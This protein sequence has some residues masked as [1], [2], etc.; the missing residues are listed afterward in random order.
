M[1]RKIFSIACT[2]SIIH[3][4]KSFM[5]SITSAQTLC[6][7]DL[8][9]IFVDTTLRPFELNNIEFSYVN[10]TCQP[11]LLPSL[12]SA[13][14]KS[15]GV[16]TNSIHITTRQINFCLIKNPRRFSFFSVIKNL[17]KYQQILIFVRGINR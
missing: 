5:D 1:K 9:F 15:L 3:R 10:I 13:F 17:N 6:C 2:S 4:N 11:S 14:R 16:K 12:R 7:Q 8:P